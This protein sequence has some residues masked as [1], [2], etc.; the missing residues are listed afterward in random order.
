[1]A[2]QE[3]PK[4]KMEIKAIIKKKGGNLNISDQQECVAT[5]E[6]P[7]E[8]PKKDKAGSIKRVK[9]LNQLIRKEAI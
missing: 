7:Y 5:E 4:E 9:A 8:K 1:M 3:K 6:F 2:R